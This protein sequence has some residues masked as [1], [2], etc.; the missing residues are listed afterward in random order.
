M[1]HHSRFG[2]LARSMPSGNVRLNS[3]IRYRGV[4]GS[5]DQRNSIV[6]GPTN[7]GGNSRISCTAALAR[8]TT[9][10]A[11]QAADCIQWR[12]GQEKHANASNPSL[13][14]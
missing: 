13:S 10:Y 9:V 6:C 3:V 12:D 14:I 2:T 7:A 5:T 1:S 4:A 11:D 8:R